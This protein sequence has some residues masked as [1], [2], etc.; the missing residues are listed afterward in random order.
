[1]QKL[2]YRIT[3]LCPI[4]ISESASGVNMITTRE[5]I[6]GSS[7]LGVF[8]HKFIQKKSLSGGA[9]KNNTFSNWFLK[10][11]LRFTNAYVV[12]HDEDGRVKKNFPLPFSIQYEKGDE[13]RVHDLLHG[14]EESDR[15]TIPVGGFGRIEGEG[16]YTQEVKKSLNFHH[17]RDS[18]TGTAKKGLF[19]NYESIDANQTFEGCIIGE[20]ND[21]EDFLK[22]FWDNK[23]K[24]IAYIGRSRNA[25]YG[26]VL[27]EIISEAPEDFNSEIDEF[28]IENGELSLTFLSDTVIYNENGFSTTDLEELERVLKENLG[29]K[30]ELK[31]AFIKTGVVEN[32]VSVWGLRKPSETCFLAGCCFLVKVEGIEN[33]KILEFQ[34][35]GIGE[36]RHE[37][38]GRIVFGW[39]KEQN[40]RRYDLKT[41]QVKPSEEMPSKVKEIAETVA[42]DFIRKQVELKAMNDA[43]SFFREVRKDK[44]GLSKSLIGR[45]EAMVRKKDKLE[46]KNLREPA[47]DQ[48]KNMR[49]D[50][51][52]LFDFLDEFNSDKLKKISG[53]GELKTVEKLGHEVGFSSENYL[54]N[55]YRNYLLTFFS[56]MRRELKKASD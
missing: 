34:K 37:G 33:N 39:Q 48:L 36:R 43:K 4:L 55:L 49:N 16:L 30:I 45:L 8:A 22:L 50:C 47:K 44:V 17:Q 5:Y 54:K 10:G 9:H 35:K 19:F 12:S 32:F 3:T 23:N 51:Q 46:L 11:N 21:L 56:T 24:D 18:V 25:Q 6:P 28:E 42:K 52:T 20:K 14:D 15:Q 7:V 26:K 53:K 40:L 27:L 31:K 38:L 41:K 13:K 1:M 2:T 29:P